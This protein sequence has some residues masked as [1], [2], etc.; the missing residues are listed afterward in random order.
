[1]KFYQRGRIFE[2]DFKYANF[3]LA[4]DPPTHPPTLPTLKLGGGGGS[5]LSNSLNWPQPRLH[6][7]F[8]R[9]G[10]TREAE[11][12]FAHRWMKTEFRSL[13]TNP[14]FATPLTREVL[15]ER[16]GRMQVNEAHVLVCM[17]SNIGQL[18]WHTHLQHIKDT[19][20]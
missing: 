12:P 5:S 17:C 3:F 11:N 1:M 15:E 14:A 18:V 7:G 8:Y 4:S 9:A 19:C 13:R 2:A 20:M 6:H 10:Q 16:R